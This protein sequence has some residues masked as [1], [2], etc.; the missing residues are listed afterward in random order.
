MEFQ[1]GKFKIDVDVEKTRDF[2]KSEKYVTEYC[3]CDGCC[4]YEKAVDLFPNEVK[5]LFTEM[6]IELKKPT[7]TMIFDVEC[8]GKQLIYGGFYHI[9]GI[10]ISDPNEKNSVTGRKEVCYVY[11]ITDNYEIWFNEECDLPEENFPR[12]MFQLD[13]SFHCPWVLEKENSYL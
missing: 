3:Q 11:K 9:C 10:V 12:P 4:N 6:G 13:I 5:K 8:D 1:F 2:Y 7:E